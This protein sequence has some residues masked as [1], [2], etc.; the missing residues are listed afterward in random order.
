M[1]FLNQIP[2]IRNSTHPKLPVHVH[3][4]ICGEVTAYLRTLYVHSNILLIPMINTRN[5]WIIKTI[6]LKCVKQYNKT[7][8]YYFSEFKISFMLKGASTDLTNVKLIS[9]DRDKYNNF[10][11]Y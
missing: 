9:P 7:G 5:L 11:R 3:I 4:G 6:S 8:C 10:L 2:T 1:Q